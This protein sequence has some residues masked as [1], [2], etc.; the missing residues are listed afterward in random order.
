MFQKYDIELA[1]GKGLKEIQNREN[2]ECAWQRKR[3][4]ER[5]IE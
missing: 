3:D 2:N 5:D 1:E 4:G